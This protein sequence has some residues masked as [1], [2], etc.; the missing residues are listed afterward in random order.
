MSYV[1]VSTFVELVKVVSFLA[2]VCNSTRNLEVD[3]IPPLESEVGHLIFPGRCIPSGKQMCSRNCEGSRSQPL[4]C[5]ISRPHCE[6]FEFPA[7]GS[8]K[9]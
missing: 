5:L 2:L 9:T 7:H 1:T 6:D 4:L 8:H 3:C